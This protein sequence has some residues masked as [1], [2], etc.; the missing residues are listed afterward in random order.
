MLSG[1]NRWMYCIKSEEFRIKTGEL[2][3][4]QD[5][6]IIQCSE[7]KTCGNNSTCF[8]VTLSR[9]SYQKFILKMIEI[10]EHLGYDENDYIN[11]I[12]FLRQISP[13]LHVISFRYNNYNNKYICILMKKMKSNLTTYIK[14]NTS[15][16]DEI[17]LLLINL[18]PQLLNIL[19]NLFINNI[20]HNDFK[21]D[22]IL[23][24]DD[25]EL[26]LADFGLSEL[27]IPTKDNDDDYYHGNI[28]T[29]AF[30]HPGDWISSNSG[31]YGRGTDL[32]M[33]GMSILYILTNKFIMC[34]KN[35]NLLFNNYY[36]QIIK[37]I[38]DNHKTLFYILQILLDLYFDTKTGTI[39][40]FSNYSNKDHHKLAKLKITCMLYLISI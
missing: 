31:I 24:S 20:I 4:P 6:K 17:I 14:E 3:P 2:N 38:Y 25:G 7:L 12:I 18:M 28:G 23:I 16:E 1:L 29:N 36:S 21:F 22:N 33:L 32:Y 30:V 10:K 8:D 9:E 13:N 26:V 35:Y 5:L 39:L 11:E 34:I 27:F 19:H 15:N 40:N 37:K